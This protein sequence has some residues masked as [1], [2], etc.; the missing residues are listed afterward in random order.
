MAI[1]KNRI[2][3]SLFLALL[4]ILTPL[5]AAS[6]VTTFS[7]GSSEVVIEFK[8]GYSL[9][10]TT[11]GGFYLGSGETITSATV[12]IS[13]DPLLHHT[14]NGYA[15]IQSFSWDS[16]INNGATTFDNVSKFAFNKDTLQNSVQFH[17]ELLVTDFESNDGGFDNSTQNYDPSGT[18]IAWDLS[19]IHI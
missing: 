11:D 18:P 13:S 4:M 3:T 17:S 16:S 14:S 10:N 12:N 7:D 1:E 5:A 9:T 2:K 8:D 15:G 6:T 19:L